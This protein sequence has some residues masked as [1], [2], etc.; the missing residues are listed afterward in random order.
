MIT[1]DSLPALLNALG[2]EKRG[3]RYEKLMGDALLAV[4]FGKEEI[5]YPEAAGLTV[6]ERQT[7]NLV[8]PE[9]FVVLECVHRL[10]VKGYKAANIELEPKWKLGHGASG[11]RAD[12]LVKDNTDKPLLLIE[13]KTAGAEFNRAWNKTLQ[14]GDQLFS[15]AQQISETSFL[16][17]YA[18]D[19]RD[20]AVIYE[21]H[22]I[23]HRDNEQYL[24]D[25]PGLKGFKSAANVKERFAVWRDTYKLDYATKGIFE[26]NIPAWQ[27]GKNQYTLEDLKTISAADQQKKYHEF[28]TILR[29]H[30]VSGRENA[31]DKLVNLL[32]C[33]LVDETQNPENLKFYWKGVAHDSHFD[34]F[35]RLQ[36]LYKEGMG[37]FLGESI[38]YIDRGALQN[39]MRFIRQNPDATQRAVW[40]LFLQQKFFTNN[41][42]SFIDVHNER[43]FYQNAEVLLKIIQ[44]WQDIRLTNEEGD[45]QLLGDLFEGFLDQGVKQSEGQFFT[46][47]P[48]CRFILM[49][50]PLPELI[51]ERAVPPKTIDYACGV[52]H[53]LTEFARQIK[54]LVK[55]A[56]PFAD[57]AD[58]HAA[59][60]GVEKEYRLSKVAKVAAFMHGQRDIAICY[61]DALVKAH[62]NFPQIMDDSFD[63]LIANPPYSVRGFLETL[64][65]DERCAYALT[66]TIDKLDTNN[67]IE[68]FFIERAKQ[69]LKA[70][71][72]AAIILPASILSNGGGVYI[73]AREIL[74]QYFDLVAIAEFGSG[75]FGKTGT[76]T[77]TLFLRRKPTTPDAAEHYR[78]RVKAWFNTD[79]GAAIY[80]DAHLIERYAA[81]IG[82][83]ADDYKTLLQGDVNGPW[84]KADY[85]EA[86]TQA[87]NESTEIKNLYKQKTFSG[88]SPKE[89]EAEIDRRYLGYAQTLEREKLYYFAL[90]SDQ[91]NPVLVIKSPGDTKAQ[92]QFLGYDWSAAKGE[93]GIKIIRDAQGRHQTALYDEGDRDN[94]DKLNRCIADNFK[95]RLAAIPE[96][97]RAYANTARL[98]EMLDFSRVTFE[99]QIALAI[100][101]DELAFS[102]KY[103]LKTLNILCDIKSGGTPLRSE[104]KYWDGEIKWLKINDFTDYEHIEET[105]ETISQAGLKNS[106]AKILPAGTV[107]V[108]IFATIGRVGIIKTPMATNQAIAGLIPKQE[109]GLTPYY[110]MHAIKLLVGQ[111]QAQAKG[112]AQLNINQTKLGSLAIP[113]PPADI[114]QKIVAE[115]EAV[116]NE[117]NAAEASITAAHAEIDAIIAKIYAAT[118]NW[119][120][121]DK[122]A[123]GVQ[124]GLSEKMNEAGVGYRIFRMNEIID[125][126]MADGGSMKRVEI[127]AEEFDKY[128]LNKGD[129]LFN[130]T[131]GSLDHVGKTGL[132]DLD[133]DYCFASYLVRIVPDTDKVLP[134]F[135]NLMMNSPQF[136]H[137]AISK[138][139]KSAGQN[140]INATKMRHIKI[141]TPSLAEQQRVVT[142]IKTEQETIAAAKTLIAAAPARKDAILRRYL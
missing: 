108:S 54:P 75:T 128:R 103:P 49:S 64:P 120:E 119:Q 84:H 83:S 55:E 32:L 111:L 104:P 16:C 8:A 9:N 122:L 50:L 11:G 62:E 47:L 48:I 138:A 91:E 70:G 12:I 31:F 56:H 93:E 57:I 29:Q 24:E 10:L 69:L 82:V 74:L 71:G 43:L 37:K 92:K 107:V 17:L 133:G 4:D 100:R 86:Y 33:K 60:I 134:L 58:Y 113:C 61:G 2:F 15:Y 53:F 18:S 140:N 36:Q 46:P 66:E 77:V 139:V 127:P 34:L 125:G 20:S 101:K 105:S 117:V 116:D 38:T 85:F 72:L 121:I 39:A 22:I 80:R 79:D 63:L 42:F 126:R 123:R 73:R 14:D 28:A 141:P 52:G 114:Q 98:T 45:S 97:L 124:Y 132:F 109:Y 13:C 7:C 30:N 41:D 6:N 131:N 102:S 27:I 135:L 81:H 115:C 44:M 1:K 89:Q 87:F 40:Q 96:S 112:M 76:N 94:A 67:S 106:S 90:A 118:K 136:R 21:N 110:V 26:A 35:D 95:G 51:A 68:A 137:E 99:K 65:E 88:L 142:K 129:L 19:W 3:R 25:N 59:M 130:R 5:L 78:E 23:A